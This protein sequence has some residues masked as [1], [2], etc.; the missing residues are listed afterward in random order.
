MLLEHRPTFSRGSVGNHCLNV[1]KHAAASKP[2]ARSADFPACGFTEL[3][4]SVFQRLARNWGLDSPQ[5][6]QT[7]MSALRRWTFSFYPSQRRAEVMRA[8]TYRAYRN[9]AALSGND[10]Q[11]RLSYL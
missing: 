11:Q 3:S 2:L 7:G 9:R 6:P 10:I 1:F 8:T 5:E 4:S